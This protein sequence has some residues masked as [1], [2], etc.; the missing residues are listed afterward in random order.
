MRKQMIRIRSRNELA[1]SRLLVD[2]KVN[3]PAIIDNAMKSGS[4]FLDIKLLGRV[5]K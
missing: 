5:R 1:R 2:K 3:V 4:D